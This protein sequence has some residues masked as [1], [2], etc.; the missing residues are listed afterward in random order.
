[1]SR[2]VA[3]VT[4]NRASNAKIVLAF[5][6]GKRRMGVATANLHT[7]T[8]SPLT[9]LLV[10][11]EPPWEDIDR[12]VAE[13]LPSQL[14]VGVPAS[15]DSADLLSE[16]HRFIGALAE[17]YRLP[18]STVDETLTSR[19]ARSALADSRRSGYLRRRLRKDRVDRHAACLIAEQW[20]STG[21][22]GAKP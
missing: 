18:V 2:A 10:G 16:I 22:P 19:A 12:I 15:S 1:L 13:W 17:R 6:F 11:R 5:D 4:G 3:E 8:A 14:V 7:G 21:T 20:L 9:T